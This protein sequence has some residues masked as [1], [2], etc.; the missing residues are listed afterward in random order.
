MGIGDIV[1]ARTG[2]TTGFN[3]IINNEVE[4]V[5]AS[6]LIRFQIDKN[7]GDPNFVGYVLQSNNFQ[8][9]VDAIAGGSAYPGANA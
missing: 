9:Y 1:I 6:Y 5:F 2:A 8:D 3:A 7:Q 4:A